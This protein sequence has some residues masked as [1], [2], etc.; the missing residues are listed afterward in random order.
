MYKDTTSITLT[1]NINL[2]LIHIEAR[3][4]RVIVSIN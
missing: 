2:V 4:E 3:L 1:P